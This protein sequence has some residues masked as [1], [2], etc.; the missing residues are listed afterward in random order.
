MTIQLTWVHPN[1]KIEINLE[2][3]S[4]FDISNLYNFEVQ[5]ETIQFFWKIE[6][7]HDHLKIPFFIIER[8]NT[9]R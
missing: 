3:D 5:P 6:E 7:Y 8:I 4:F 1:N 2:E 9:F